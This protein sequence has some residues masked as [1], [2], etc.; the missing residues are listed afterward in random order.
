MPKRKKKK[1]KTTTTSTTTTTKTTRTTKNPR[2][3]CSSSPRRPF[4][5][6]DERSVRKGKPKTVGCYQSRDAA[7]RAG[8][9]W[10]DKHRRRA[11]VIG[12]KRK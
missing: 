7:L 12:P 5:V 6:V 3:F 4:A 8:Q 11:L 10:A 1:K 2:T 9:K